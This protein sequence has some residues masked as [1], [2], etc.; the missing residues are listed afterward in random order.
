MN[1]EQSITAGIEDN[2]IYITVFNMFLMLVIV[3]SYT[4]S[5]AY[6]PVSLS[7]KVH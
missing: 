2:R 4:L 1:R 5:K 6:Q 3:K 7:H